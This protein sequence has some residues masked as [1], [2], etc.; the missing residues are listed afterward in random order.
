VRTHAIAPGVTRLAATFRV[1]AGRSRWRVCFRVRGE[2]ARG[3]LAG[4]RPC[5]RRRPRYAGTAFSPPGLPGARRVARAERFLARRRGITAFALVDT[6]GRLHGAHVHRRF[7]TA[8]VVKAILL[9][10]Y[11]RSH[12]R[13]ARSARALLYP[14]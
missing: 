2:S 12:R 3:P 13:L 10:A 11:L 8:S 9:V 4:H 6:Q 1:P 14:M 5:D 7:V